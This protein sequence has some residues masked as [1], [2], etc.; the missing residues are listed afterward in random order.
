MKDVF[1]ISELQ[2]DSAGAAALSSLDPDGVFKISYFTTER[3][4]RASEPRLN[5]F[6]L[7]QTQRKT[8]GIVTEPQKGSF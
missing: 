4:T 1:L 3:Y 7:R 8:I 6:E 2:H 5:A